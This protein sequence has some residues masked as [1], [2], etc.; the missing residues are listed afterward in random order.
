MMKNIQKQKGRKEG[1][2]ISIDPYTGEREPESP[3]AGKLEKIRP[4]HDDR[5]QGEHYLL[6]EETNIDEL[7]ADEDADEAAA[8]LRSYID[9]ADIEADFANRQH[10]GHAGRLKLK[11]RLAEHHSKSP[12]I[13]GGD[14]DADWERA[15][16]TGEEAVGGSVATPDQDNVDEIGRA[17][18]LT[19]QDDEPLNTGDKLRRRD[20]HRAEL[21]RDTVEDDEYEQT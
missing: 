5:R 19:Y 12:E 7:A 11:S 10:L 21:T 1:R 18:G 2:P 17:A 13:S 4:V 15:D 9:D 20:E 3:D 16:Q 8:Y 14:V 6:N